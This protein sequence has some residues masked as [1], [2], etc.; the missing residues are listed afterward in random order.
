MA[1]KD[2]KCVWSGTPGLYLIVDE[3][4]M[5][6]DSFWWDEELDFDSDDED[7]EEV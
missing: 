6:L 4:G 2:V 1:E 3:E 5:I 7:C